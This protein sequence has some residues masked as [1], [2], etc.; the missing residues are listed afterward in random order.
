[1]D[2]RFEII[3]TPLQQTN[4]IIEPEVNF[5]KRHNKQ[6]QQQKFDLNYYHLKINNVQTYDENEYACETT[7]S[8]RNDNRPNLQSL[9]YLK[10]T[11]KF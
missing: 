3:Q 6:P 2:N 11:R 7:V 9:V 1:M 4:K 5:N 8:H 10:I